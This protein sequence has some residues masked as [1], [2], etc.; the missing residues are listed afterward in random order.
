MKILISD[1]IAKEGLAILQAIK[2]LEII[3]KPQLSPA[4]LQKE[5]A[6]VQGLIVRS[7]TQVTAEVLAKAE[8]LEIIGRAGIGIDNVDQKVA[9]E[10]G[11]VIVNTPGGNAV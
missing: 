8:K 7:N 6:Q 2:N 3:Y 1:T 5:I 4:E 10:K 11:I 9:T